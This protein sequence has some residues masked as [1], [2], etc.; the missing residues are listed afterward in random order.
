ME[1]RS[2]SARAEPELRLR[3]RLKQASG[4]TPEELAADVGVFVLQ[5]VGDSELERGETGA[6][7]LAH[8]LATV[9]RPHQSEA[10]V[11]KVA[12]VSHAPYRAW[13][14]ERQYAGWES[15]LVALSH[16]W[17]DEHWRL[18]DRPASRV[19]CPSDRPTAGARWMHRL[20]F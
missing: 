2:Q 7:L 10:C 14:F 15:E 12:D 20:S 11:E 9:L 6:G 19:G 16:E 13:S 5:L 8:G 3:V 1:A 4:A 18:R 17:K